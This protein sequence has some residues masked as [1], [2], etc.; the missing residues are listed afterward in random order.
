MLVTDIMEIGRVYRVESVSSRLWLFSSPH[1]EPENT[2]KFLLTG[3]TFTVVEYMGLLTAKKQTAKF[4]PESN[5]YH[6]FK[7]LYED[8]ILFLLETSSDMKDFLRMGSLT[9]LC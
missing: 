2:P 4:A 8:Q 3:E 7:V 9:K 6:I 1:D 5:A